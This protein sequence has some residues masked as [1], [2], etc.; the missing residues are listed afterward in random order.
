M[1]TN[2]NQEIKYIHSA[3]HGELEQSLLITEEKWKVEHIATHYS[4]Y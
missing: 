2:A 1:S 4:E 3:K